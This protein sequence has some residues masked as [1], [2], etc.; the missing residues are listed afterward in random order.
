MREERGRD[1]KERQKKTGGRGR[2]EGEKGRDDR[3]E[4]PPFPRCPL[5]P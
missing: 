5:P 1:G 4:L 2:R 3:G